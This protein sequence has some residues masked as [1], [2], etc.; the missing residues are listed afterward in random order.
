ME[1]IKEITAFVPTDAAFTKSN[2]STPSPAVL[3]D[4]IIPNFAGYVPDL[5]DGATYTLKSGLT[6]KVTFKGGDIYVNNAKIVAS[7]IILENGVA[8]SVDQ[9]RLAVLT[10]IFPRPRSG[11]FR[12][13]QEHRLI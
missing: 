8:H 10:R 11:V 3:S 12:T 6:V 4:H 2:V 5:V 13:L 7:N 9:V 1:S